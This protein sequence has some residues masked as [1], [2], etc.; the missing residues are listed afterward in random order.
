MV[1]LIVPAEVWLYEWK[2]TLTPSH[3]SVHVLAVVKVFPNARLCG[4]RRRQG[5]IVSRSLTSKFA[6]GAK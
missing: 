5:R 6:T 1:S 4:F 2:G 3:A